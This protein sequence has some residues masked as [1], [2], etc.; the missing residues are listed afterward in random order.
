MVM[1]MTSQSCAPG[2]ISRSRLTSRVGV[3]ARSLPHSKDEGR[4]RRRREKRY[5]R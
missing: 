4:D 3:V 2:T 5:R 1:A